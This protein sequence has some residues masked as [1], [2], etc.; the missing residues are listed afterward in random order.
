MNQINLEIIVKFI[1]EKKPFINL[2]CENLDQIKNILEQ[3]LDKEQT[4]LT[5]IGIGH[6]YWCDYDDY[7]IADEYLYFIIQK[8]KHTN[9]N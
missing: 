5:S 2:K 3:L 1:L 4:I 7:Q 6:D 9:N 8:I